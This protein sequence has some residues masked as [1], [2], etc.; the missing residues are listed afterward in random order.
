M[1]DLVDSELSERAESFLGACFGAPLQLFLPSPSTF[2]IILALKAWLILFIVIKGTKVPR[3][4]GNRAYLLSRQDGE[5][6]L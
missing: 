2:E 3:I 4:R 5:T 1:Y 6:R